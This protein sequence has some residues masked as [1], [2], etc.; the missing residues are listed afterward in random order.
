MPISTTPEQVRAIT[1]L[2]LDD[3]AL[4]PFVDAAL[5]I[6]NNADGC[7]TSKGV[8]D[9]CKDIVATWLAAHLA[10]TTTIGQSAAAVKKEEFEDWLVERV[11]GGFT[12][13]GV[14]GTTHGQNAN[15][16]SRGC[17]ADEDKQ[18]SQVCFFG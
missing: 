18:V 1:G 17:L 11:V 14:L 16:L 6:A 13:Q 15:M 5:C 8:T 3:A 12:G 9:A 4:Q 2:T 10:S 7:M